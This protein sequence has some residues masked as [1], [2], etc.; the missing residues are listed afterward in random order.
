MGTQWREIICQ[1]RERSVARERPPCAGNETQEAGSG[2][3][4]VS[5]LLIPIPIP[6]RGARTLPRLGLSRCVSRAACRERRPPPAPHPAPRRSSPRHERK[7]RARPRP[8][9]PGEPCRRPTGRRPEPV[10]PPS[11]TTRSAFPALTRS[12]PSSLT[13]IRNR[14]ARARS[15]LRRSRRGVTRSQRLA[16][17]CDGAY[18]ARFPVSGNEV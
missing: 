15:A 10:T 17:V 5:R 2:V 11:P 12:F 1:A 16:G 6:S 13:E 7:S 3:S 4:S 9:L 8:S 18:K 14:K